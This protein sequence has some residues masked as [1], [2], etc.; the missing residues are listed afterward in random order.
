M[1]CKHEARMGTHWDGGRMRGSGA[2]RVGFCIE[3]NGTRRDCT[4]LAGYEA[5]ERDGDK[6]VVRGFWGGEDAEGR[7]WSG[8]WVLVEGYDGAGEGTVE[9][10]CVYRKILCHRFEN[11]SPFRSLLSRYLVVQ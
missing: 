6:D 9:G 1:G 11:S 3:C 2:I 7:E 5:S 10:G 8:L 4:C